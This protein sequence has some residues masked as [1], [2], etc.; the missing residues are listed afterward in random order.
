[1]NRGRLI[2]S[3]LSAGA[4]A[5]A[6]FV[7]RAENTPPASSD[8]PT[9][10]PPTPLPD[11]FRKG[12]EEARKTG[13][14]VLVVL[15]ISDWTGWC[16]RLRV[17]IMEQPTFAAGAQKDFVTV[18]LDF[19][20]S[21]KSPEEEHRRNLAFARKY[22]VTGFPVVLLF[23]S[24]G[25][26]YART[27]YTTS[28]V[29]EYVAQLGEL[30]KNRTR[31]DALIDKAH[32]NK[33]DIRA[34]LLSKALRM[35]DGSLTPGYPELFEELRAID[36]VDRSG[37]I[38]DYD[39]SLLLIRAGDAARTARSP[40]AGLWEYDAFLSAHAVMPKEKRQRV[41]LERFA[42]LDR[43]GADGLSRAER[44][45]R[46]ITRLK[47]MLELAPKSESATKIRRLLDT[48]GAELAKLREDPGETAGAKPE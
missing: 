26:A 4:F 34:D 35:I 40:S 6:P 44:A 17:D 13:R 10:E 3:L 42:Y 27:G 19:P 30:K 39:I 22:N 20:K 9:S 36:P 47:E 8:K 15:N 43:S 2:F 25:R 24:S 41:L 32:R 31:R 5:L 48:H 38:L 18:H 12:I 11:N 23:D 28:A 37:A 16:E 46:N 14:D 1:M 29:G 45:E 33:G 21:A 7:V